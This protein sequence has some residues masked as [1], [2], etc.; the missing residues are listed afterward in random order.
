LGSKIGA[1]SGRFGGLPPSGTMSTYLIAIAIPALIKAGRA[2]AAW[3]HDSRSI[4]YHV[5]VP[6]MRHERRPL[7]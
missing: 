7:L 4:P 3:K 1:V 6:F 2:G 5:V